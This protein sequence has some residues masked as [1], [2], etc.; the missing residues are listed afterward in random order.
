VQDWA[1][2]E[3]R[4]SLE[5]LERLQGSQAFELQEGQEVEDEDDPTDD[6]DAMEVEDNLLEVEAEPRALTVGPPGSSTTRQAIR[7]RR[8]RRERPPVLSKKDNLARGRVQKASKLSLSTNA[9]VSEL[10]TGLKFKEGAIR[11][12]GLK[13]LKDRGFKVVSWDGK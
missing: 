5:I 10:K 11:V 13:E 8:L 1:L 6:E 7:R 4:T 12:Y 9:E 3:D 2:E